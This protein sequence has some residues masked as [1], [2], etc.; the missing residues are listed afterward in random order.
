MN[1]KTKI[2]IAE[3]DASDLELIQYELNNSGLIY[4]S[5]IVQN[6][7][8]FTNALNYFIPDVILS[9]FS[10][11]AFD[12]P[13]AFK[14]RQAIAP[15]TPFIFVSGAI[16]E[17][18][19]IELIKIGVTDY[20]LKGK[21]FTLNFKV[22]RALR[23]T[24]D[25]KIKLKAEQELKL[26]EGR[27]VRA[28]QLAHI[29][30]WEMNFSS[31]DIKW[32][33]EVCRIHGLLPGQNLQSLET[34]QSLVHP[35]DRSLICKNIESV[36]DCLHDFSIQYRILLEDGRIKYINCESKTEFNSDG[37]AIGL[38]GTAQ[39]VTKTVILETRLVNEMRSKQSEIMAAVLT[40]QENERSEI[41]RELHDNLNQILGATKLY[42]ELAK[43]DQTDMQMLLK[44]STDCIADV[45]DKIRGISKT[46][47][48]PGKQVDLINSIKNLLADLTMAHPIHIQLRESNFKE[49]LLGEKLK[50]N[51]FRIVQEQLN[52]IVKHSQATNAIIKLSRDA[53][54][55]I[56]QISDNGTG[57]DPLNKTGGVGIQNIRSRAELY[58]GTVTIVSKPGKGYSL[59][60]TMSMTL[61]MSKPQLQ[62]TEPA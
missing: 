20:V 15:D 11:P 44:K 16:G 55:V 51:I 53:H 9:D 47:A 48:S 45:M 49:K 31:K 8:G 61:F 12:G 19:S 6:E 22:I 1:A 36:E 25:R 14:I 56:L 41:G 32:S 58:N 27:L 34:W 21:L 62:K 7:K 50:L 57:Y 4:V 42:I 10:F 29:G 26:S 39:D 24:N 37:K 33:D 28:Q 3:H 35:E 5:E 46:L 23:E 13:A 18:K 52:N 40:A 2:L 59:K 17:E 60:V 43:R 54:E 30:H 38:Y